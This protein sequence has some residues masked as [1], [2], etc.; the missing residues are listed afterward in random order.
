MSTSGLSQAAVHVCR[1]ISHKASADA[2]QTRRRHGTVVRS[3]L[4]RGY[5]SWRGKVLCYGSLL[6]WIFI[7]KGRYNIRTAT[8]SWYL[9]GTKGGTVQ[10]REGLFPRFLLAQL[11]AY[12]AQL[13]PTIESLCV[14][15]SQ[16]L[17]PPRVLLSFCSKSTCSI[18][19]I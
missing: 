6:N 13:L 15:L 10:E 7:F 3:R 1:T 16:S 9:M 12:I 2:V 11:P 8:E 17:R 5:F 18:I 19:R 14:C 4:S